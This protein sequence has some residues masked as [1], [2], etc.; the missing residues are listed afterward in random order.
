[1][2]VY[3]KLK[4]IPLLMVPGLH[5]GIIHH[6]PFLNFFFKFMW[7]EIRT[8]LW[9]STLLLLLFHTYWLL[10]EIYGVKELEFVQQ[11]FNENQ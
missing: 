8:G 10:L 6:S 4:Y 11:R 3:G 2:Y 1:M 5:F 9:Q 7:R